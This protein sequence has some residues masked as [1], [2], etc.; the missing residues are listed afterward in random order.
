[1]VPGTGIEPAHHT[2]YAPKAYAS[3]S[4]AIR[5]N[6]NKERSIKYAYKNYSKILPNSQN[7]CYNKA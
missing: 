4:S 7:L 3:T 2:V 5:A 6:T 1:M